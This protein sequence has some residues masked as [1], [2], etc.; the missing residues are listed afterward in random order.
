MKDIRPIKIYKKLHKYFGPQHWWP[1]KTQFEVIVGAI[2]TQSTSWKNVEK[3]I[4]SLKKHRLLLPRKILEVGD[5][6]L[7]IRIKSAG[8][9]RQKAKKLKAF[10]N[11]L[12]KFHQGKLNKL[13]AQPITRLRRELLS[14]HGI[15]PETAD[16]IILY[17]AGQPSFVVDAYTKRIGHRLGLFKFAKYD[18][19]KTFFEKN[20]PRS[21]KIYNE[22]H[23]LLV[24]LG[25][26]FCRKKPLCK[27][28]VLNKLCQFSQLGRLS[29]L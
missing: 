15:G 18:E 2:L 13:F 21:I 26:R 12:F 29:Q 27:L 14:I 9:Y 4:A 25:K 20:L 19:I 28:C 10:V 3:A 5:R 7:E 23:A 1:A 11:H 24:E 22:F 6:R 16:S 17:A 8:Y